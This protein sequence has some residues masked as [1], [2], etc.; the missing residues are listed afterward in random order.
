MIASVRLGGSQRFVR[1]RTHE[2]GYLHLDVATRT[3][4]D[5]GKPKPS[6][7]WNQIQIAL[8]R[9]LGQKIQL[10]CA[11][12]F[13]L[14]FDRLPESNP[15]KALSVESSTSKMS[16][17]LTGGTFSVTGAPIE[18]ITWSRT[19]NEKN[20][21]LWLRSI[22]DATINEAYLVDAFKLL[23]ETV[24]VFVLGDEKISK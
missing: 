4:F 24:E 1:F 7:T 14:P 18:R 12:I 17:K 6:H 21:E 5:G 13:S 11:G 16:M 3:Y 2:G 23:N 22:F 15:I 20:I 9:F 19:D 10:R 8:D